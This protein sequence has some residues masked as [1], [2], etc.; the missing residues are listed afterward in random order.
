MLLF[1]C[2]IPLFIP[3]VY[4]I[5][6]EDG[7]YNP[8]YEDYL[9]T[10]TDPSDWTAPSEPPQPQPTKYLARMGAMAIFWYKTIRNYIAVPLMIVSFATCGYKFFMCAFMGKPEYAIDAVKKQFINTVIAMFVL[11]LIPVVMTIVRN[12][13][14]STQWTPPGS[15]G[16]VF[17]QFKAVTPV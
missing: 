2:I 7:E 11:F 14:E 5:E 17:L 4:A 12:L 9:D 1:I 13:M 8:V 15:I 6:T 16:S 3:S 10:V